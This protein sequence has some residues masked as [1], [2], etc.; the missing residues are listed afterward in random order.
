[1]RSALSRT[2]ITLHRYLGVFI[3][4]LMTLWCLSGFVMMYQG[5][6]ATSAEERLAGLAPLAIPAEL[7]LEKLP[8]ADD[9]P[10]AD[11]RIERRGDRLLF[12]GGGGGGPSREGRRGTRGAGAIDIV[13]G[14]PAAP[15]TV[16]EVRAVALRFAAGNGLSPTEAARV[17]QMGR[18]DQWTIQ[19]FER[20]QPVYHVRLGD[21]A[22]SELYISGKSGEVIQDT[23]RQERVLSWLGAI[24]H[25]L[26]PTVLRR[27]GQ[28]WTQLVIWSAVIG[29][30]LTATGLYIGIGRWQ[31]AR[32]RGR[33]SPYRGLWFWHHMAGLFFGVLTLTWVV[34]GLLT[35]NPWGLLEGRPPVQRE[36]LTGEPSWADVKAAITAWQLNGAEQAGAVQ[37]S[38]AP[39]GNRPYLISTSASAE[40]ARFGPDGHP[41]SLSEADVRAAAAGL[42][43][44][45]IALL[46]AGDAYHYAFKEKTLAPAW[47]I[48]LSDA[49]RTRIY[50]DAETGKVGR[51]MGASGRASRWLRNGLHSLDFLPKRPVWD[52]VT[53]LLLAGVT[54]VCATGSWMGLRRL[55]RDARMMRRRWKKAV[56]TTPAA[57][58][59]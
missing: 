12:R 25:W 2:I 28:L 14:K 54:M 15:L 22:G 30:F 37:L 23:N 8:F 58:I 42:P 35:M 48:S 41:A 49:E 17:E 34:S 38:A 1:M 26:Y 31:Q 43:V 5:F 50:I 4:L 59:R 52:G 55:Q 47:R 29:T 32:T 27:N 46:Q 56:A 40:A 36:A 45:D 33:Q 21:A 24:P 53:L 18:L 16:E 39:L 11:F 57:A 6:P 9:Q 7:S 44:S 3:G 10:M 19:S 20:A 51:I 13:T